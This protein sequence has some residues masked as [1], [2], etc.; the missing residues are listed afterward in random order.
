MISPHA[1][2]NF[3]GRGEK[4]DGAALWPTQSRNPSLCHVNGAAAFVAMLGLQPWLRAPLTCEGPLIPCGTKRNS[5]HLFALTFLTFLVGLK[6]LFALTSQSFL[7]TSFQVFVT[8]GCLVSQP[9]PLGLLCPLSVSI[10]MACFG[11]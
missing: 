10:T 8:T 1:G 2:K 4:G 11:V 3:C 6:G 7:P 9:S 5:G